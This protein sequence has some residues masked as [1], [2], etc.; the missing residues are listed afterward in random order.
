MASQGENII[1][2]IVRDDENPSDITFQTSDTTWQA[3][4]PWGGYN[5]Y[6]SIDGGLSDS[7]ASAVSY[8][9]PIITRGG[10]FAAGPQDFIFG[11]EYPAIRWL[12][13]NGYNVNYIS[14]VDTARDGAQLLNSQDLPVGRPRRVLVRRPVRQCDGGAGCWCEPGILEW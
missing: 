6:G 5:L 8:N 11:V 9:R 10:G 14:G 12:E 4:N 2:F 7:R 13:Q 3:Y 1:P